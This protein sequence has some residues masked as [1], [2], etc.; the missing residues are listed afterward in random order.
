MVVV[1]LRRL[2][3]VVGAV[4][5]LWVAVWLAVPPLLKWQVPLR[6]GEALGR[7]VSVG[8]VSFHPWTLELG[9]G[10]LAI[11]GAT[12]TTE[13]LLKIAQLRANVS[14]SSLFRLAPV[15]E[16]LDV[17]GLRAAVERRAV[18]LERQ[19]RLDLDLHLRR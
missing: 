6:A 10:E 4:L 8:S 5:L 2:A 12:P 1:W 7:T 9:L 13:P 14:A 19:P 18:E 17:D 15:I 3:W 11:G 16:A